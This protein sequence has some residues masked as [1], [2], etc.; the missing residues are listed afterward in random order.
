ME[1]NTDTNTLTSVQGDK[2][3]VL[4]SGGIDSSTCLAIACKEFKEVTSMSILYGQKHSQEIASARTVAAWFKAEHRVLTIPPIKGS[5][6]TDIDEA[7]PDVSYAEIEGKSPAYVPFRN[8]LMISYLASIAEGEGYSAIY[9][10]AHSEDA[11]NWAYAD[12][13]MEF[14]GTM[15][16]AIYIGT[17]HKVRLLT[18][19]ASLVKSE[20]ITRGTELGVPWSATW[21]CYKANE[22]QCGVCPTC[23]S[24]IEGF[25]DAGVPDKTNYQRDIHSASGSN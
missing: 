19:L 13:T 10:G 5:R 9:F 25:K 16:S 14:I 18:P 23:R 12:C 11:H 17:Y 3:L 2:A 8:G 1:T 20:I 7:I 24:R 4:H 6:L 21:S 15:A 22:R